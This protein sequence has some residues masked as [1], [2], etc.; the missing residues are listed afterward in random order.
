MRN[1]QRKPAAAVLAAVLPMTL[2]IT[3][4][5]AQATPTFRAPT[6][7]PVGAGASD[8]LVDDERH[9]AYVSNSADGTISVLDLSNRAVAATWTVAP[10]SGTRKNS[11]LAL[12]GDRL[13]VTGYADDLVVV[14]TR[15]G[16]VTSLS[17]GGTGPLAAD[18]SRN[19][20]YVAH[21]AVDSADVTVLD[22]ITGTVVTTVP[23][24]HPLER[25]EVDG[26]RDT[27]LG[28]DATSHELV[29]ID[30]VSRA[31]TRRVPLSGS[32]VDLAVDASE[33]TVYVLTDDDAVNIVDEATSAITRVALGEYA[34]GLTVDPVQHRALVASVP[35]ARL[36]VVNASGVLGKAPLTDSATSVAAVPSIGGFLT[37]SY[38]T[39]RATLAAAA[40]VPGPPRIG[41]ATRDYVQSVVSFGSPL[42]NGGSKVTAYTVTARDITEPS[43]GGQ[44][45]I[46]TASPIE[47]HGLT[48][49]DSYVFSVTA[50][51]AVGVGAPSPE[52]SA[53]V[54][55]AAEGNAPRPIRRPNGLIAW[56]DKT[57]V[58]AIKAD[59]TGRRTVV[60]KYGARHPS[61]S[62]NGRQLAYTQLTQSAT[63]QDVTSAAYIG[64]IN[65]DGSGFA[66]LV[67]G[68]Q[69]TWTADGHW[70]I[71]HDLAGLH[72]ISG[73]G[74]RGRLRMINV[75]T[76]AVKALPLP[77]MEQLDPVAMDYHFDY[78]LSPNGKTLAWRSGHSYHLLNLDGTDHRT[79]KIPASLYYYDDPPVW[80]ADGRLAFAC[81]GNGNGADMCAVD[82][83]SG[84]IRDLTA[85]HNTYSTFYAAPSPDRTLMA[86]GGYDAFYVCDLAGGH[87]RKLFAV[88]SQSATTTHPSWQSL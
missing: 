85:R 88:T 41:S 26:V 79:I 61:W 21:A 3:V 73:G 23:V 13:L 36:L 15:D 20:V 43:R 33:G 62:P 80:A 19:E 87:Y 10:E 57:G 29:F 37:I 86:Y 66:K 68:T 31:V 12:I 64:L 69:P 51:N 75:T 40:S 60:A 65:A 49:G 35:E 77:V 67:A 22:L 58:H 2:L 39:E 63:R 72:R 5:T 81:V 16:T 30:V 74:V 50:T 7:L 71:Y 32:P 54:P 76:K 52:T 83:L 1:A 9:L 11:E 27:L 24:A 55:L 18:A 78:S 53:V 47:V 34:V 6:D 42:D 17:A 56:A 28:L 44:T 25:L 84:Q 48:A 14:D 46:G 38:Q 45:A 59:G 70:V 8:V 82:L 4:G